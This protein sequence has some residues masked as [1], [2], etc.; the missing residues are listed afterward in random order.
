MAIVGNGNADIG[1]ETAPRKPGEPRP[2]RPKFSAAM[3]QQCG[4]SGHQSAPQKLL[5]LVGCREPKGGLE[6]KLRRN[7][8]PVQR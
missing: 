1:N 2:E 3:A 5:Q 7:P 8:K 4:D 6:P